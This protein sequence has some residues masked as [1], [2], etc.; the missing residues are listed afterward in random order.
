MLWKVFGLGS[1]VLPV[2]GIGWALA[3]FE[4]LGPLSWGRA[5]ALAR[6]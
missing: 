5:A 1:V 6:G 3:A 2:L 4:R